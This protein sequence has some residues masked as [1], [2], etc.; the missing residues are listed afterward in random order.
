MD[1]FEVTPF[2]QQDTAV[3]HERVPMSEIAA[4]IERALRTVMATLA[5]QGIRPAGPPIAMYFGMPSDTI[6]MEVGVPIDRPVTPDGDVVAGVLPGGSAVHAV[7]V[8]PYD[9][10]AQTYDRMYAWMQSQGIRPK[11][12]MWESYLSDPAEHPDPGTLHTDI[13]WPIW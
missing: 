12:V 11:D 5:A 13:F 4:L 7:H 2:Q 9:A 6:E 10:L 3:L 1:E 8:G